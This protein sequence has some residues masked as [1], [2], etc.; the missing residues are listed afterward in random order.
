MVRAGEK[1][2]VDLKAAVWEAHD[3]VSVGMNWTLVRLVWG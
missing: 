1:A 3:V 2:M